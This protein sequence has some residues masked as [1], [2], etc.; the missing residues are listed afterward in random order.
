MKLCGSNVIS[1]RFAFLL[2]QNRSILFHGSSGAVAHDMKSAWTR[3]QGERAGLREVGDDFK[4]STFALD[5]TGATDKGETF[6]SVSR[7]R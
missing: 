6:Q 1:K 7:T 4:D 5:R 2:R 3:G